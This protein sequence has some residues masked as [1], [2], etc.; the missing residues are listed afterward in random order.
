MSGVGLMSTTSAH[1]SYVEVCQLA[2][3][4]ARNAGLAVFPCSAR[5]TPTR[6]E[7][8]GGHGYKDASTDPEVIAWLWRHWPGPL[9]GVATG[10]I[11]DIW[12]LDLD[13]KH[14]AA[15]AWW[16]IHG[17]RMP[18]TRCQRTFSGG[19]HFYLLD[20]PCIGCSNGRGNL[21]GVD[22]R[23]DGGYAIHWF[24]AGLPCLDNSPPAPWPDWLTEAVFPP[25]PKRLEQ[26]HHIGSRNTDKIAGILRKVAEAPYGN[27]NTMLNWAAYRMGERVVA[28]AIVRGEAEMLLTRA[29]VAAGMVS[30]QERVEAA[31][32]IASGL[33]GAGA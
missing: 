32:T 4:V 8:D 15:R 13:V 23:G 12:V 20:A 17:P 21:L 26:H 1:L 3:N 14:D 18:Q 5:K 25:K 22:V 27:R 16:L 31:R 9:I 28:G 24:A 33:N 7:R 30:A 6:P 2:Q 29:S 11:S 10:T 19:V